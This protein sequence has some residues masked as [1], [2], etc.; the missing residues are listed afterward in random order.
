ADFRIA[1]GPSRLRSSL[2]TRIV[3]T[4]DGGFRFEGRGFGH[5]VGLCQQGAKTMAARGY[6]AEAILLHYFPGSEIRKL[7]G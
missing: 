7:Y 6:S 5:G 3:E 1:L 2:L 4:P